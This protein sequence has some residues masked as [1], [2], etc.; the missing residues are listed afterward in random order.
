MMLTNMNFHDLGKSENGNFHTIQ[1]TT[2]KNKSLLA[3]HSKNFPVIFSPKSSM[4]NYYQPKYRSQHEEERRIKQQYLSYINRI[5][6]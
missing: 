1:S 5:N 6:M 4:S 3:S 2:D